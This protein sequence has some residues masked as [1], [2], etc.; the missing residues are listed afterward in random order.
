MLTF[1]YHQ[2]KPHTLKLLFCWVIW[3]AQKYSEFSTSWSC[4][5]SRAMDGFLKTHTNT[6]NTQVIHLWQQKHFSLISPKPQTYSV[7]RIP[8]GDPLLS[9]APGAS[10]PQSPGIKVVWTGAQLP[11]EQ[12]QVALLSISHFC[13]PAMLTRSLLEPRLNSWDSEDLDI[14]CSKKAEP[15]KHLNSAVD[16]PLW[17]SLRQQGGLGRDGRVHHWL[18]LFPELRRSS[19]QERLV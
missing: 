15:F 14:R 16:P 17:L 7:S 3:W 8:A 2:W 19:R 12:T 5:L 10:L 13:C 18:L 6:C 11:P 9:L 1:C 4:L